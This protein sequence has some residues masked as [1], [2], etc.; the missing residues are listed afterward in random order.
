MLSIM[1]DKLLGVLMLWSMG[2]AAKKNIS[3]HQPPNLRA[4]LAPSVQLNLRNI[5]VNPKVIQQPSNYGVGNIRVAVAQKLIRVILLE[6]TD[7]IVKWIHTCLLEL[8]HI[9][10]KHLPEVV[11]LQIRRSQLF[12]VGETIFAMIG[13]WTIFGTLPRRLS[14]IECPWGLSKCN[15]LRL[16]IRVRD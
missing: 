8:L 12:K 10:V 14:T 11:F 2:N 1:I 6:H 9:I 5:I 13:V 7:C 3:N 4:G 16:V 15:T